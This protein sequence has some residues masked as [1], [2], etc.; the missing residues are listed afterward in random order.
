MGKI[1]HWKNL[2]GSISESVHD[3]L[4]LRIAYL[5]AENRMLRQQMIGSNDAREA[6]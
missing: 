4:R 6:A 1:M 3:E 5:T 2:R